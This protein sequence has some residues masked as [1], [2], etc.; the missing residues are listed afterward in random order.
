MKRPLSLFLISVLFL[1]GCAGKHAAGPCDPQAEPRVA[2]LYERLL[3]MKEKGVMIGHQ[4]DLMYG[5]SWEYEPGRSDIKEVCGSYPAVIGWDLGGLELDDSCNLDGVPFDRMREAV[6]LA[7]SMGCVVTFS[8]HQRNPL[9][10]GSSWDLSGGNA[11]REIL[12]G[13]S[14]HGLYVEWMDKC[15]DFMKSLK[16]ADGHAIPVVYRPYHENTGGAFWWGALSCT[17]ED[18]IAIWRWTVEYM[19]S[20]GVHNLLY[21]YSTDIFK[22][23]D[24]YMLRY[25]GDEWVDVM[26]WDAYHRPQDWDFLSG[27]SRMA[28][29]VS[30]L[31]ARH[32]KLAA[33]TET[34]LESVYM[35]NWWT[36]YLLPSV[37]GYGLSWVLLWRNSQKMENHFFAPFK[38]H[39][40]E[41]DFRKMVDEDDI[42]TLNDMI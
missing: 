27:M 20:A 30:T 18:Y 13:G 14:C 6:V 15:A 2:D 36:G 24:E 28:E 22:D 29:T 19:Y 7:D 32:H 17:P 21:A 31:A 8:W 25:P 4:D 39:G 35:D 5:H 23:A 3:R 10:G 41:D 11:V 40:S 12:P 1:A 26:G 9:T 42:L 16:D 37:R 33:I 38:G 34:G